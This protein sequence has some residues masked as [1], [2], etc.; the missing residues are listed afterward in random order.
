MAVYTSNLVL[1]CWYSQKVSIQFPTS[2]SHI[3]LSL[4]KICYIKS[5]FSETIITVCR[6]SLP[7]ESAQKRK[8]AHRTLI[9]FK[10]PCSH[11]HKS[12]HPNR[13]QLFSLQHMHKDGCTVALLLLIK[14]TIC[15]PT[16]MNLS[17][18]S[19]EK[20]TSGDL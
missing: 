13:Q 12:I 4:G 15:S 17:V 16:V 2:K 7:H 5:L 8:H 1:C 9:C 14:S 20:P 18:S 19:V 3:T 6:D 11:L 10:L